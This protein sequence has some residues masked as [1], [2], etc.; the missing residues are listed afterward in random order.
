MA[1]APRPRGRVRGTARR[2]AAT[3]EAVARLRRVW[4]ADM[5]ALTVLGA[6]HQLMHA[7]GARYDL[8]TRQLSQQLAPEDASGL[9]AHLYGELDPRCETCSHLKGAAI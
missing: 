2:L 9:G 1:V 4:E 5:V 8:M 3:A 6:D 7:L